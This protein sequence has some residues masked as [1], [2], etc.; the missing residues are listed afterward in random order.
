MKYVKER[1]VKYKDSIYLAIHSFFIR[2]FTN[3]APKAEE[4]EVKWD[5]LCCP[6]LLGFIISAI[7]RPFISTSTKP[8]QS[9]KTTS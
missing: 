1:F 4:G 3:E 2:L 7:I 8:R 9:G 5:L 6:L